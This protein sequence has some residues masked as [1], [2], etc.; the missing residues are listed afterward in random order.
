MELEF[1]E[2]SNRREIPGCGAVGTVV[3]VES[4]LDRADLLEVS[5]LLKSDVIKVLEKSFVIPHSI[6]DYAEGA[7]VGPGEPNGQ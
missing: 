6:V 7:T 5:D 2:S 4:H 3:S 1:E